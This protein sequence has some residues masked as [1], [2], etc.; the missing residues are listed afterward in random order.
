MKKRYSFENTYRAGT[1]EHVV[2][3][4][5]EIDTSDAPDHLAEPLAEILSESILRS[6]IDVHGALFRNEPWK[7]VECQQAPVD[8]TRGETFLESANPPEPYNVVTS[9]D[10]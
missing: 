10:E 4:A 5:F 8:F 7:R 3:V 1:R 6:N 2:T 9:E